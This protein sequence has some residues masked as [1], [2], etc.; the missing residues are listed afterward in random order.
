MGITTNTTWSS[1]VTLFSVHELSFEEARKR[2]LFGAFCAVS[3]L[4]MMVFCAIH[5]ASSNYV[6][7]VLNLSASLILITSLLLARYRKDARAFYRVPPIVVG[8][9]FVYFATLGD[10]SG[11]RML[12]LY[13]YPPMVLFLVGNREGVAY[14]A[15]VTVVWACA[16]LVPSAVTGPAVYDP[17]LTLRFLT[18]YGLV[19]AASWFLEAVRGFYAH[20][21][22]LHNS[23]LERDHRQM[24]DLAYSDELTQLPNR[25]SALHML[26]DTLAAMSFDDTKTALVGMLDIDHFKVINDHFGHQVGDQV[27]R[28]VAKRVRNA[29]RV[30]DFVGRY[31]GE[32]FLLIIPGAT[33]DQYRPIL[34][35]IR[36]SVCMRP[37]SVEGV[38][39]HVTVS[40]GATEADHEAGPGAVVEQADQALYVAKQGGRNR[41]VMYAEGLELDQTTVTIAS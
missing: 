38:L 4:M 23:Q 3:S 8:I 10:P 11:F 28:S 37:I 6:E 24:H 39:H 41:C 5:L 31:G 9:L 18:S 16:L 17:E 13:A 30:N 1:I 12:W 32:E 20:T 19:V 14:V 29:V 35:K 26:D 15:I 25:R 7:A 27:L 2:L 33:S 36:H 22:K 40:I 34:E 21:M